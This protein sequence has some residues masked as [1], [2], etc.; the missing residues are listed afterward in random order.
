[1]LKPSG[2]I[3]IGGVSVEVL[4]DSETGEEYVK[5]ASGEIMSLKGYKRFKTQ[6]RDGEYP[7]PDELRNLMEMVRGVEETPFIEASSEEQERRLSSFFNEAFRFGQKRDNELKGRKDN[8][9]DST[10]DQVP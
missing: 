9:H 7:V 1:M 2:S 10:D 4:V 8:Q 5:A 6:Q 3:K